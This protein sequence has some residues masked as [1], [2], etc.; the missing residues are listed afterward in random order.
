MEIR[1][2]AKE[3]SFLSSAQAPL[4]AKDPNRERDLVRIPMLLGRFWLPAGQPFRRQPM[5]FLPTKCEM[6]QKYLG[7][8]EK[9]KKMDEHR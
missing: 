3:Q 6:I 9:H 2:E 8:F 5:G 7:P 4:P 1:V